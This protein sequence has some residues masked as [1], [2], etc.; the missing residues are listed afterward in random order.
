MFMYMHAFFFVIAGIIFPMTML[1]LGPI[2][3][4]RMVCWESQTANV[5]YASASGCGTAKIPSSKRG[6]MDLQDH[7]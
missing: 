4:E 6:S 7:R 3:G 5:D 1:D 2:A